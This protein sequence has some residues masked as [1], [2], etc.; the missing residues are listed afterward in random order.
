MAS[1]PLASASVILLDP[2]RGGDEPCGVLLLER[3]ARSR[4][5]PGNF[6]FP[7]GRVEPT[8]GDDPAADPT[9]RL[10]AL[11]ELWEESG[12]L[13]AREAAAA[14]RLDQDA[15][16][17]ARRALGGP[18]GPGLPAVLAGLGLSPA[19]ERLWPFARW[20]TPPASPR[21]YDTSF[22]LA[23]A[24]AGQAVA[25][26]PGEVCRALWLGPRAALAA[27]QAG[28]LPLAP[29][30]VRLLGEL[31]AAGDPA[32]LAAGPA[33][34]ELAPVLPALVERDGRRTVL[35]PWDPA[36]PDGGDVPGEPCPAETASRLVLVDG[37]WLPHRAPREA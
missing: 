18:K 8:D 15:R 3:P 19:P 2:A 4:F 31:A 36:Y 12:M 28:D 14:A 22:Y 30:Q 29:P 23:L 26:R 11:R 10:C 13:L 24:P 20:I 17:A 9:R 25:C 32:R 5:M 34:R 21:R 27:N 6:V 16:E 35:L 1:E 33:A 37:R 7:G